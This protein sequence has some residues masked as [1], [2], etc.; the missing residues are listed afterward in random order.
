MFNKYVWGILSRTNVLFLKSVMQNLSDSQN[1]ENNFALILMK[2][3]CTIHNYPHCPSKR[4]GVTDRQFLVIMMIFQYDAHQNSDLWSQ[5]RAL[6]KCLE[7]EMRKF[8]S[9]LLFLYLWF[10]T[11][12]NMSN[13]NN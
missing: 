2:I 1:N 11:I 6:K 9:L 7:M 13:T 4:Y 12:S 8:L 3:V 10:D 5:N